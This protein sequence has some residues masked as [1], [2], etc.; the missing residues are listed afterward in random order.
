MRVVKVGEAS[1]SPRTPPSADVI[2]CDLARPEGARGIERQIVRHD[3]R[4]RRAGGG[5]RGLTSLFTRPK[6]GAERR[7]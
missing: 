7:S 6:G 4:E 1:V 5:L 2:I 3:E